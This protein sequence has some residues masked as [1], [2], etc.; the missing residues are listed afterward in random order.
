MLGANKI[1]DVWEGGRFLT[2]LTVSRL[3][4]MTWAMR[5][6]M[7]RTMY[8]GSSGRLGEGFASRAYCAGMV[9]R[10]RF[11]CWPVSASVK[12]NMT[13]VIAR[14]VRQSRSSTQNQWSR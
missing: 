5:R 11:S 6:G 7:R 1:D 14:F 10:G 3:T 2:T 12:K 4:V 8:C 9:I 13:A